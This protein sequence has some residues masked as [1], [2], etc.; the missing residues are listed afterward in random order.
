VDFSKFRES[1]LQ[2][3]FAGMKQ[4]TIVNRGTA[5]LLMFVVGSVVLN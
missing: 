3:D 2:L 4:E 5:L 1:D